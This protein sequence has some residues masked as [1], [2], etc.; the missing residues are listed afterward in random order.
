[1]W[2]SLQE[3]SRRTLST[4]A[5]RKRKRYCPFPLELTPKTGYTLLFKDL[6]RASANR[7]C[8]SLI[9][10]AVLEPTQVQSNVWK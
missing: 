5:S 4:S 9:D 10:L 2:F 3:S 8:I 1:M 6:V 7:A